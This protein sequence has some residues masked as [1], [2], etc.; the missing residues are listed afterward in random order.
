V[1]DIMLPLSSTQRGRY[2]I[3]SAAKRHEGLAQLPGVVLPIRTALG[4]AYGSLVEYAKV[5]ELDEIKHK[6][7]KVIAVRVVNRP[8]S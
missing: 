6:E 8:A 2:W 3:A 1:S 4:A 5:L 7:F